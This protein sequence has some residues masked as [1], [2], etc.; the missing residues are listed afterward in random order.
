MDYK[1]RQRRLADGLERHKLNGLVVTHTVNVRYLCGFTGS[2]AALIATPRQSVLFTDGR[3]TE[4]AASEAQHA[5]VVIAK[6]ALIPEVAKAVSRLRLKSVG[7]EAQ[8][9]SS[10][11]WTAFRKLLPKSVRLRETSNLVERLREI[12]EAEEIQLLREAVLAGAKLFD[13]TL[14][15][16]RPGV[17]ETA[18][19]AEMEY[20]ARRAGAEGMAF[21][22]IVAAG[23]RSALPHGRASSAPIPARGFVVLDWGVRLSGYCS[24]QTRTVHVGVPDAEVRSMYNAV[25]EA[26]QAAIEAVRP[27]ATCA[28]VDN[29][30]RQ[31]L[32]RAGL[33]KYFAHSTG[34]GVG[35]EI[36]E[37]PRL[38]REQQEELEPG[39]VITIEPGA[40]IAN[41]GG[42]RIEDMVVVTQTGCE[43]LT[44]TTKALITL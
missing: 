7:V 36:H 37:G 15:N 35:L 6:G 10:A 33:S 3:Y 17:R 18:V 19:A 31:V 29:A 1:G 27:G 25:R 4:Q 20:A 38:A 26:Q 21:D 28:T 5:R 40:Y 22:T 41:R 12:K 23:R 2:N 11:S 42:V 32:T 24:D 9:L 43:V 34:H 8:H 30:A 14:D 44:P 13:S 39:M 16:I